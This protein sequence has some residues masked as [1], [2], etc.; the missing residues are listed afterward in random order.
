MVKLKK[1]KHEVKD[2]SFHPKTICKQAEGKECK[3]VT[4]KMCNYREE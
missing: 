1:E 3:M 2:C 4:K